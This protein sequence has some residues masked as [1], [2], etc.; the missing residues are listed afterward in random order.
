M[1]RRAEN[2][3]RLF[4]ISSKFDFWLLLVWDKFLSN[5]FICDWD[6]GMHAQLDGNYAVPF[7]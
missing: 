1:G 2:V 7:V 4:F 5:A 6:S 3:L